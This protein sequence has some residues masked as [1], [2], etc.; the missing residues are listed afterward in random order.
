DAA[1]AMICKPGAMSVNEAFLKGV[2]VISVYPMPSVEAMN[3]GY[4]K[5]KDLCMCA[6]TPRQVG[7]QLK[8]LLENP[9]V[10]QKYIEKISRHSKR[11]ATKNIA[12]YIYS[13]IDKQNN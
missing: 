4:F 12:D 8:L 2:P 7:E 10:R 9:E 6:D 13:L 3:V 5:E 1:D 11:D